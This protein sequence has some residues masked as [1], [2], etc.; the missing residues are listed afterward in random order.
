[1]PVGDRTERRYNC[2]GVKLPHATTLLV[3]C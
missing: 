1:L 3:A 2:L